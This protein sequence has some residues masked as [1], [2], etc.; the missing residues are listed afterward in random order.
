MM[1]RCLSRA[2]TVAAVALVAACTTNAERNSAAAGHE[3]AMKTH[4]EFARDFKEAGNDARSQEHLDK[5]A[6]ENEQMLDAE[7]GLVCAIINSLLGT[8][9]PDDGSAA[10][11][12]DRVTSPPSG[13][14][15]C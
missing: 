1:P 7:C 9:E 6:I 5:A 14:P 10:S 4:L 12:R 3:A 13:P 8:D 2:L 11:C 15:R